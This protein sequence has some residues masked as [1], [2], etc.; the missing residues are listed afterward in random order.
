MAAVLFGEGA[1]SVLYILLE[2]GAG[3]LQSSTIDYG[4]VLTYLALLCFHS[5]CLLEHLSLSHSKFRQP[6]VQADYMVEEDG[7]GD[8]ITEMILEQERELSLL[9]LLLPTLF[10]LLSLLKRLQVFLLCSE[11]KQFDMS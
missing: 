2:Y 10:L 3:V 6:L 4:A 1:M 9:G 11:L 7:D 5:V 8:G